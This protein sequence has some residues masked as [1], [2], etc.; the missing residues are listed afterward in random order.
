MKTIFK[1]GEESRE[2]IDKRCY[3]LPCESAKDKNL[4]EGLTIKKVWSSS[5]QTVFTS[6]IFLTTTFWRYINILKSLKSYDLK[7]CR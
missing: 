1:S 6:N 2:L 7:P 4:P 3:F 5:T